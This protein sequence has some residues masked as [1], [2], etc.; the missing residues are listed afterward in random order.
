MQYGTSVV[1]TNATTNQ[2]ERASSD[3]HDPFAF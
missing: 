2:P 3:R 1:V